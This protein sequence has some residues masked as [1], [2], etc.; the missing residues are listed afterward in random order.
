MGGKAKRRTE[1]SC[2]VD[3][4]LLFFLHYC[5]LPCVSGGGGWKTDKREKETW[6]IAQRIWIVTQQLR[7]A[8]E[9]EVDVRPTYCIQQS[10]ELVIRFI[11]PLASL[12]NDYGFFF[13]L[14]RLSLLGQ[15]Q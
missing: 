1:E 6:G 5:A 14:P 7:I 15:R 4:P 3:S 11:H 8:W 10:A 13:R 2:T 9:N 12:F